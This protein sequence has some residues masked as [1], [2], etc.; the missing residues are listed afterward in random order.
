[1]K[2]VSIISLGCPKNTVDSEK[3][4]GLL[5]D[6]GYVISAV[7]EE[8]DFVIINTC[9][10]IQPAVYESRKIISDFIRRKRRNNFKL[11]VTGCLSSRD[12]DS[13]S[14]MKEIDAIIGLYRI[15]QLPKIFSDIVSG[16]RV[17]IKSHSY[18]KNYCAIPRLIST[19][20]Y[21]YLKIT[22]GCDNHCSY[23]TIPLIRGPLVSFS[24][25]EILKEAEDLFLTG[26]KEIIIIGHDTTSYGKEKGRSYLPDLVKQIAKIGFPWIRLMYLH[27]SGITDDLLELISENKQVCKY[28]DV[29]LQHV[30][31]LILRKMNRPVVDY[32]KLIEKIR[33]S[34]PGITLR[35]TFIVGFPGET[36]GIFDELIQ[37]IKDIRFERLGAFTYYPERGTKAFLM[38][39]QVPISIKKNRL[40]MLLNVQKSISKEIANSF[41]DKIIEVIIE[42]KDRTHFSGRSQMDAP[43][44]DWSV[45]VHGEANIGNIVKVRIARTLPYTLS[46]FICN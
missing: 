21:A 30:H 34:V 45:K 20:P 14:T 40:S 19:A 28:L 24:E 27:P 31:P 33:K 3:I 41:R 2:K 11:I 37:F 32:K 9:A 22:E 1:M 44:I 26:V 42:K 38:D 23:C 18:I 8:S 12:Y 13:L 39:K 25:K 29:P 16:K 5:G 6:A 4:L 35:T 43:D 15:S 7:P 10:F 46:G 36:E 17:C